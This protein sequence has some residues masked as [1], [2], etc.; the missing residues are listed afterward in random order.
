[1]TTEVRALHERVLGRLRKADGGGNIRVS[2]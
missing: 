1:M 2:V